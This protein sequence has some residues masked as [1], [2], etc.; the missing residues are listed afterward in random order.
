MRKRGGGQDFAEMKRGA[1]LHEINALRCVTLL[2]SLGFDA[3][4]IPR[5]RRALVESHV[6]VE[7]SI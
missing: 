3:D 5:R 4:K 2:I 7:S 1:G 6:S